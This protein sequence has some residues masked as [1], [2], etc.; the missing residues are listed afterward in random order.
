MIGY[1]CV[2]EEFLLWYFGLG[3]KWYALKNYLMGH[4]GRIMEGS[5]AKS[6]MNCWRLTGFR[7]EF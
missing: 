3:M 5:G 7:E 4:T 2:L 1:G 6:Y